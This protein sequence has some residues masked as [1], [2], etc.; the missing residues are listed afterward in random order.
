MTRVDLVLKPATSS[1]LCVGVGFLAA[2]IIQGSNE[3]FVAAGG[4]CG[5]VM[6][7]LAWLGWQAVPVARLGHDRAAKVILKDL[8]GLGVSCDHVSIENAVQTPIVIQRFVE[9]SDGRRTHRFSLTC[10]EC[11]GWLPRYR[12]FTLSQ[13]DKLIAKSKPPHTLFL[14]RV[15]PGALRIAAWAREK[16]ALIVFEPSSIGDERQFQK[17]VDLC[18]VLKYSHDRLGHLRDLGGAQSP[19]IIVETLA[20]NG[21]KVRW[22]SQWTEL[23][24]FQAPRF[25]DGAGSGDWCSAGLIHIIGT[26]GSAIFDTLQK[27]RLLA[28]LRFGQALA[29]I[30]CGYEG[31]RGAM[32]ALS[33][34]QMAKALTA[35]ISRKPELIAPEEEPG[36]YDN[37]V[38][39]KICATCTTAKKPVDSRKPKARLRAR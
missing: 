22:R 29:A 18:H 11:G 10:P 23:R 15:S 2:D 3:E 21:L 16:G 32:F 6:A 14:D 7:V 27:P 36:G 8:G 34:D 20:E 33:R 25:K 13:A 35:L 30:N 28:A 26:K 5:N 9:E 31:A 4:S 38:P 37:G 24:A 17:A 19:Q 1:P 12:S 39:T